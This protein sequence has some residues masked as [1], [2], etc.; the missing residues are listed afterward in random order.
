VWFGTINTMKKPALMLCLVVVAATVTLSAQ[1]RRP[2][3]SVAPLVERPAVPAD[4]PVRLALKVSLPESLHS[5]SNRPLDPTLIPTVLTID[6]PAGVTVDEVVY[7]PAIELKQQGLEQPLAVFEH[8]FVVGAQIT[9]G[10]SVPAGDLS[11]PGRLRYQ[12]CNDMMC[13]P[14]ATARSQRGRPPPLLRRGGNRGHGPPPGIPT[15]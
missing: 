15:W 5:Q 6:A 14:P 7:P 12:A 8:E 1:I 10:A 4:G 11:V 13:F 2:Q 3:A 9:L